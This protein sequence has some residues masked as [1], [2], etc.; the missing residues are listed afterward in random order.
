MFVPIYVE[1]DIP[2]MR[3]DVFDEEITFV[4]VRKLN[5]LIVRTRVSVAAFL[6]LV[7][8]EPGINQFVQC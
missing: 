1:T 6:I 7:I 4:C 5:C 8:R 2:Q 3:Q